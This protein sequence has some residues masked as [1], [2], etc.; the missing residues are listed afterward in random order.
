LRPLLGIA[1]VLLYFD[2]PHGEARRLN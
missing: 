2:V 1:F